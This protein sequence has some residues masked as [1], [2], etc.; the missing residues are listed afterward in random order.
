MTQ[1]DLLYMEDAIGHETNL[2]NICNYYLEIGEDKNIID[3]IKHQIK[4]HSNIRTK[5]LNTM[6]ELAN[7]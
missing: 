7:E 4:K 2:I 1:K 3:F 5:L 6:K